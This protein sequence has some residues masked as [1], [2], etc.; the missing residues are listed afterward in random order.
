MKISNPHLSPFR[1]V[2]FL[3]MPLFSKEGIG[4]I[5]NNNIYFGRSV[6]N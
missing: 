2:G 6:R 4:E 5:T 1:K 3:N